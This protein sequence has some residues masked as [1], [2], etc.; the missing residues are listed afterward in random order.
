MVSTALVV[1]DL[2]RHFRNILNEVIMV[3]KLTPCI[4]RIIILRMQ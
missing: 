1:V 3:T 4:G 2:K